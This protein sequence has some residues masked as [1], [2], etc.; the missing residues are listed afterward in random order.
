[1]RIS[2]HMVSHVTNVITMT[3]AEMAQIE[4]FKEKAEDLFL[5]QAKYQNI[6][7]S[8]YDNNSGFSA[9]T[10]D[11]DHVLNLALK[12][13][14]FFA[15]KE[16]T[17]FEKLITII[18]CK[19]NDKLTISYIDWL[20]LQYK[21]SMKNAEITSVFGSVVSNRYIIGLWFNSRFFHSDLVK[22]KELNHIHETVGEDV[23]LFQ[24]YNA[25]TSCSEHVRALYT[26]IHRLNNDF[27][28]CTPNHD[29]SGD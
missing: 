10:P 28:L 13:R 1:M 11:L 18:R 7:I 2:P 16:P 4:L 8:L 21:F 27:V 23:S 9:N 25:I 5:S 22:R 17:Q 12:F 6:P 26:I 29:F 20:R 15:D 14:F 24:L 19:T 3:E